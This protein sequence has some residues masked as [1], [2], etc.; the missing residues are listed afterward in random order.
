MNKIEYLKR[1][2]TEIRMELLTMIYEA[3][4]GH[5][6]GSLSNTDI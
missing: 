6:G 1:K 5:T 3:G 2:A 4:T